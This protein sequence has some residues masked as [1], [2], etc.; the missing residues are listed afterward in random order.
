MQLFIPEG[1]LQHLQRRFLPPLCL[2]LLVFSILQQDFGR[3]LRFPVTDHALLCLFGSV[4]PWIRQSAPSP[5]EFR[6]PGLCCSWPNH[7]PFLWAAVSGVCHPPTLYI[8]LSVIGMSCASMPRVAFPPS[9]CVHC[10]S[11][12]RS[13]CRPAGR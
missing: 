9:A 5:E 12:T 6:Q 7:N 10:V 4:Y 3:S 1:F 8:C 11:R 2:G 13:C